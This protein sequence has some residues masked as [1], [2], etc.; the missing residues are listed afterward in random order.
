MT[1]VEDPLCQSPR[2]CFRNPKWHFKES[3]IALKILVKAL[4]EQME[5]NMTQEGILQYR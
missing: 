4:E 3:L 5:F 2:R 1:I